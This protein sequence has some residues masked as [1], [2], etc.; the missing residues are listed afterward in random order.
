MNEEVDDPDENENGHGE[1]DTENE[2]QET[3]FDL[4]IYD[5]RVWDNFYAKMRDI[6]VQN[7]RVRYANLI[8]PMDEQSRHFSTQII[9]LECYMD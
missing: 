6:L 8:F 4:N 9:I 2:C 5:S 1:E 3:R 7:G